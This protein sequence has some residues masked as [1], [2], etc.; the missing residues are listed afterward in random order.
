MSR[1]KKSDL[2]NGKYNK[3][4]LLCCECNKAEEERKKDEKC[5]VARNARHHTREIAFEHIEQTL[6]QLRIAIVSSHLKVSRSFCST[7]N[8]IKLE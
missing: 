1:A 5:F 6:P 4:I 3:K 2:F 8:H 7:L